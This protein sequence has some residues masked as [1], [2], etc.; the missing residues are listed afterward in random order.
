MA[1]SL[2]NKLPV[3]GPRL[4][5]TPALKPLRSLTAASEGASHHE[6]PP[7]ISEAG[8]A[9]ASGCSKAGPPILGSSTAAVGVGVALAPYCARCPRERVGMVFGLC[10]RRATRLSAPSASSEGSL[11]LPSPGRSPLRSSVPPPDLRPPGG[12]HPIVQRVADGVGLGV[13]L[14]VTSLALGFAPAPFGLLGTPL[15]F[16]SSCLSFLNSSLGFLGTPLG[17]R[18]APLVEGEHGVEEVHVIIR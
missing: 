9:A 16:L 17:P 12:P 14:V 5:Y 7:T 2:V 11:T 4:L 6:N 13:T 8:T 18:R 10:A 15:G 3:E 1:F